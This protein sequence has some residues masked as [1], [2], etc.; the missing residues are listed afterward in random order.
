MKTNSFIFKTDKKQNELDSKNTLVFAFYNRKNKKEAELI[1]SR[2]LNST[3]I[4]C[5][6]AGSIL[7]D[8]IYE[9]ETVVSVLKLEKSTFNKK[10]YSCSE[11]DNSVEIG[12]QIGRDLMGPNIKGIILL[13]EG[14]IVNGSKLTTGINNIIKEKIY[15]GGG[16]AGDGMAFESTSVLDGDESSCKKIIAVALYGE[17]LEFISDHDG[18][19]QNF[20]PTR[21]VTKSQNNILFEIDGKPALTLYKEFLGEALSGKLPASALYY[22]L[23]IT[24]EDGETA[25]RS[26]LSVNETELSLTFAGDLPEG[27]SVRL[28]HSTLARLKEAAKNSS[29]KVYEK[30]DKSLNTFILVLSCVGRKVVLGEYTED[31]LKEVKDK[32]PNSSI[33]GFYSY[34]EFSIGKEVPCQLHNQTLTLI[35]IQEK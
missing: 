9:N 28:M 13:T 16:M 26:I 35:G 31:E 11:V 30:L 8:C 25:V 21:T 7:L 34:V 23:S 15:I 24:G 20:G 19:W 5:S 17:D 10:T 3:V 33:T 22:P 6:S 18:G 27:S 12:E 2:F 32:F 1:K 14:L 29:Q 4:G